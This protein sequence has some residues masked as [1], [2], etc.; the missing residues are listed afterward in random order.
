MEVYALVTLFNGSIKELVHNTLNSK[1]IMLDLLTAGSTGLKDLAQGCCKGIKELAFD[2]IMDRQKIDGFFNSYYH[3]VAKIVDHSEEEIDRQTLAKNFEYLDTLSQGHFLPNE[4]LIEVSEFVTKKFTL[5]LGRLTEFQEHV[6]QIFA[7][8][9]E[10]VAIFKSFDSQFT[11]LKTSLAA[12]ND[13]D[14]FYKTLYNNYNTEMNFVIK[15]YFLFFDIIQKAARKAFKA[16]IDADLEAVE[17][18]VANKILKLDAKKQ[19]VVEQLSAL[20]DLE[21]EARKTSDNTSSVFMS[22]ATFIKDIDK[23]VRNLLVA[24]LQELEVFIHEPIQLL[25]RSLK[26]LEKLNLEIIEHSDIEDSFLS[27][28]D[29]SE[30]TMLDTLKADHSIKPLLEKKVDISDKNQLVFTSDFDLQKYFSAFKNVQKEWNR[31]VGHYL[32]PE[33]LLNLPQGEKGRES[34]PHDKLIPAEFDHFLEVSEEDKAVANLYKFE[35]RVNRKNIPHNG[36]ILLMNDFFLFHSSSVT[37]TIHL[38]IPYDSVTDLKPKKNFIGQNNGVNVELKKGGIE[39]YLASSSKRDEFTSKVLEFRNMH[40]EGLISPIK[41]LLDARSYSLTFD[42]SSK[43][44]SHEMLTEDQVDN[45]TMRVQICLKKIRVGSFDSTSPVC[46]RRVQ[47]SSLQSMI[48]L[49]FGIKPYIFESQ[50]KTNFLY[51]WREQNSCSSIEICTLGELPSYLTC[52]KPD[53]DEFLK[54]SI[55]TTTLT[56]FETSQHAKVKERLTLVFTHMDQI[57]VIFS[58]KSSQNQE[59]EA[60]MIIRQD[61][62]SSGNP[63]TQEKA[64]NEAGVTVQMWHRRGL[65]IGK[66]LADLYG[67]RLVE[68]MAFVGEQKTA[69]EQALPSKFADMV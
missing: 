5:L 11:H 15:N 4:T 57:E 22:L 69:F 56:L 12:N 66:Q 55:N 63:F 13:S 28:I 62:T 67:E 54:S 10:A 31:D 20:Q 27:V 53:F 42:Q 23:E 26:A 32:K 58:A 47:G 37:G 18:R 59:Y 36:T 19:E 17:K 2:A 51:H 43:T 49:W 52:S 3:S 65:Q 9:I 46:S 8:V 24:S 34:K 39:F 6:N 16:S 60:L 68:F 33:S 64:E 61:G 25:H 14:V 40:N 48:A 50:P 44:T 45:F 30:T 38:L 21:Q 29:T 41:H 35:A 1:K 7:K